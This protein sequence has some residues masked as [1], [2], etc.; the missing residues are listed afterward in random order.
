MTAPVGTPLTSTLTADKFAQYVTEG[1]LAPWPG[2]S[3][4]ARP[5]AGALAAT[6]ARVHALTGTLA[7]GAAPFDRWLGML[8]GAPD[9]RLSGDALARQ[10]AGVDGSHHYFL[11]YSLRSIT[12]GSPFRPFKV[13]PLELIHIAVN[14]RCIRTGSRLPCSRDSSFSVLCFA[15][16]SAHVRLLVSRA[17]LPG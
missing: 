8:A 1:I 13:L 9:G 15:E 3:M 7:G 6:V 17:S 12:R 14:P 11:D 10:A 5:L 4:V 2:G 16:S